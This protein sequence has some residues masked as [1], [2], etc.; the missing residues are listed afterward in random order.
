M[1]SKTHILNKLRAARKP[2]Q[3]I[4]PVSER[5][6]V[7]PMPDTSRAALR[8]RFIT[9]A[10]HVACHV[11][12]P[13]NNMDAI[14]AVRALIGTDQR[15]LAWDFAL[16]PL[17]GLPQ[18]LASAGISVAP[19]DAADVRV[20]ITGVS[21]ALAATGSLVLVSGAGRPRSASLLPDV[22]IAVVRDSVVVPDLEAWVAQISMDDFRAGSNTVIITGPSKTA[23]IAQEL[24]LGAHGP[25]EVHVLVCTSS[26]EIGH[27]RY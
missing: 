10:Q 15:V 26:N 18:A 14:D 21:C 7:T 19:P 9:E 20:G 5:L 1:T 11:H 13:Q 25:R 27:Q 4:A 23:D 6:P 2:F 24:T 8:D 3:D 16:I 12:T 22:H 17:E